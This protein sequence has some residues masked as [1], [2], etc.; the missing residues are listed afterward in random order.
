MNYIDD[1]DN[2]TDE[3]IINII[4]TGNQKA[5]DYMLIKYQDMVR[6]KASKYFIYGAENNDVFQ[7]GM[8]GLYLAIKN[9][10]QTEHTSFK[11]FAN[12]CVERQLIT[13]I[14]SANRQK[15]QVLNTAISMNATMCEKDNSE[16]IGTYIYSDK[17]MSD[18]LEIISNVEYYK[19][20]NKEINEVLSKHERE[21][22]EE[23]KEGKSY[24]EIA[25][26]LHCNT[27]S[28][29]TAMTRIR[30]KANLIKEKYK[31]QKL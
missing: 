6:A 10:N 30:R 13:A 26:T 16:E 23:F 17:L 9:F 28:V 3:E 24:S 18:P 5:L 1:Y 7:E 8:I 31:E 15:H 11:T 29:D 14:K 19:N 20:I 25:K 22:L 4:K 12:I 21:V 27:K 2:K